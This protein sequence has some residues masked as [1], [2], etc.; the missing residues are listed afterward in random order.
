MPSPS[1]NILRSVKYMTRARAWAV[2]DIG[3]V[4]KFEN[5]GWHTYPTGTDRNLNSVCLAGSEEAW[6]VGATGTILHLK[7][8]RWSPDPQS[9]DI[10]L[11]DL[12]SVSF[13]NPANGWAVG[14]DPALGGVILHYDGQSWVTASVTGNV[15]T[16]LAVLASDNIHFCGG[17]RS[18]T[19]FDGNVFTAVASPLID[20][21]SWRGMSFPFRGLG[22]VVGD[23]GT[24]A[25]FSSGSWAVHPQGSSLTGARLNSVAMLGDAVHG[26]A[27]G[28]G[29][30]R[31][32]YDG[33]TFALEAAGGDELLDVDLP[34]ALEGAAVGGASLG[35]LLMVRAATEESNLDNIRIYP[36]PL[37]TKSGR[38]LTV[39]RLP[40]NV[41]TFE[42]ATLLGE[43]VADLKNGIS[44]QPV[45]GIVT[46]WPSIRGRPAPQGPYLYRI[47]T[48]A[49]K[50]RR[51]TFLVAWR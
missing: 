23:G 8:G 47:E 32:A 1:P 20:G 41:K 43:P 39:D 37:S 26:Y 45:T 46:W 3:T 48:L 22:W 27:V 18:L 50:V 17:E 24:V 14:G 42:I 36:N 35:R 2:G 49:G 6:A 40:T 11:L 9:Q 13:L 28:G 21:Q 29:G 4:I 16:D 5:G 33:G 44:Y 10:T 7:G 25:K 19:R 12:L 15:V 51:G 31:L 34:N 38:P 30:V